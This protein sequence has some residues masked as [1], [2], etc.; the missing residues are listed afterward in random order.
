MWYVFFGARTLLLV[1]LCFST[2]FLSGAGAAAESAFLSYK[3]WK[4][5]KIQTVE[6]RIRQ[7]EAK[8]LAA[9]SGA[10]PNMKIESNL[11]VEARLSTTL[12]KQIDSEMTNL[13]LAQDLTIA[14]YFVGYLTKQSS[15]EL[16]IKEVAA[17][18]STEEVAELMAAY[19]QYFSTSGP[20]S[21]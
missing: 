13:N 10:D 15:P 12:G 14:D 16:A 1:V 20:K 18:L 8:S 3:E 9:Q 5:S 19:A 21:R 2:I 4:N 7:L 6:G 17:K 11:T